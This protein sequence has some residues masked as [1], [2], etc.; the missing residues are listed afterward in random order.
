MFEHLRGHLPDLFPPEFGLPNQPGPPTE[1]N[2]NLRQRIV[3]GQTKAV[4]A[5]AALVAEGLN[6]SFAEGDSGVFDGMVLVDVQIAFHLN[7]QIQ[8]AVFGYLIQHV[9]KKAQPGLYVRLAC[10]FQ[11]QLHPDVCFPGT[12][13]VFHGA[14]WNLYIAVNLFPIGGYFCFITFW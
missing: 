7:T 6:K 9:I 13:A 11:V 1:I 14:Q 2:G 10:A 8:Q 5:D 4:T 3:H 12:P